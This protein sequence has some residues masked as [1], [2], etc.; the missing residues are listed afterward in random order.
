MTG[1][2]VCVSV[3]VCVQVYYAYKVIYTNVLSPFK[4]THEMTLFNCARFLL[5]R[6]LQR[7]VPRGVSMVHVVYTLAMQAMSLGAYKLARFAYNKLQVC[8]HAAM[9]TH[10]HTH[11]RTDAHTLTHTNTHTCRRTR[12]AYVCTCVRP[13]VLL[14]TSM[15]VCVCVCVCVYTH[16]R[17]CCPLLSSQR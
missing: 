16:R 11:T 1:L 13:R 12:H 8:T 15:C 7:D 4:A 14:D 17:W 2:Y 9:H 6:T 10:A 5:M 3:C